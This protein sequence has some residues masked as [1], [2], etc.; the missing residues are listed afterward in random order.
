MGK[1][2]VP[3]TARTPADRVRETLDL[4][5]LRVTNLRHSGPQALELLHLLDQT[6][7]GL[8]EL[9]ESG[10]D[11]RAE[12]ARFET[13]QRQLERQQRRFLAEAGAA[14]HKE[15][16]AAQP[17]GAHPWWFL[18]EMAARQRQRQL[19]RLLTWGT[20]VLLIL[21]GGWLAYDRFIAPPPEVRQAFQHSATGEALVEERDLQAA[22]AEFAA[23]AALTPDDPQPWLWQGI[24]HFEWNEL[25]EAQVAFD[26]ARTLYGTDFDFLLDRSLAYLRLGDLDAASADIE[27]AITEAPQDGRAYFVRAGIAEEQGNYAMALADLAQAAELAREAGDTEL[28]ATA[29]AQWAMMV[30]LQAYP[31]ITPTP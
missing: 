10:M 22:L 26:T 2:F 19:R 29:R 30:Q 25:D 12:Q 31:Q 9:E 23:A 7:Q 20:V 5:E 14:L 16:A 17:D 18:D 6:A 28:E 1:S 27:Q 13:V 15:R 24:I 11:V 21:A 3:V 8:G 4:A